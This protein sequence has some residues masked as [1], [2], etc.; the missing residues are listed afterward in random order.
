MM[1][2]IFLGT[3]SLLL[4]ALV[5]GRL[6]P[7]TAAPISQLVVFG[8]SLSD[9]GNDLVLLHVP[10]PPYFQG[11]FADGPVWV[12]QLA[13][14]LGVPVPTASLTGGSN[15]AYGG[16]ETGSGFSLVQASIPNMGRQIDSYL[17]GHVPNASQL[18]VVLGGHNNFRVGETDPHVPVND[19]VNHITAL[20][21]AGAKDFLVST[22]M[23]VGQLPESRGGPNEAALDS[24]S[25]QFNTLLTAQLALLRTSLGVTIHEFDTYSVM[26]NMLA[27]P[28]SY[29]FTNVTQPA[30]NGGFNGVGSIVGDPSKYLF[31]DTVHPTTAAQKYF[32]DAA[33][34]A[35]P[36]PTTLALAVCALAGLAMHRLRRR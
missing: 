36:E 22:L 21:N 35:V 3:L 2:H 5:A 16:A 20:A 30:F 14:K 10:Q 27:H 31:W 18:F 9:A 28:A 25:V 34:A 8:D 15:Y 32:A 17:A 26:E 29:G 4:L 1:R 13:T 23:P 19:M 11:R 12:D 6:E 33:F 24:L 7:L